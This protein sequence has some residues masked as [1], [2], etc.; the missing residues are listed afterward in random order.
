MKRD[1]VDTDCIVSSSNWA[2][3]HRGHA[4]AH[5]GESRGSREDRP[6]RCSDAGEA[7]PGGRTYAVWV[8]DAAHEAMRDLVRTRASAVRVL[9]K[10]RQ[11]L[12]GF[13]LRHGRICAGKKGWTAPYCRWLT[14]AR[15]QHPAQKIVFQDYVDAV[16]DAE[17]RAERLTGQMAEL[18]R[19]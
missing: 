3:Q 18:P 16:A 4:V 7:A 1:H 5:P 11:D 2:R 6:P 19:T 8:P 15:F 13:L 12:Q 10:A 9:G 17:A 14:A